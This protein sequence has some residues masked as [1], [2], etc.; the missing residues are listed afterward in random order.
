[1]D[2][3][4]RKL[5]IVPAPGCRSVCTRCWTKN[6][7]LSVRTQAEGWATEKRCA[8]Q[9]QLF[10][11]PTS[12]RP[13][14]R[15]PSAGP[16]PRTAPLAVLSEGPPCPPSPD[17]ARPALPYSP[18]VW[19]MPSPRDASSTVN[20]QRHCAPRISSCSGWPR[21]EQWRNYP[22]RLS[23]QGK[24][25]AQATDAS[26]SLHRT[27]RAGLCTGGATGHRRRPPPGLTRFMLMAGGGAAVNRVN[28]RGSATYYY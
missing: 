9:H 14:P 20:R 6:S 18:Q 1:M 27:R 3:R 5:W 7:T 8:F 19:L 22:L 2:W 4:V 26:A 15:R 23:E 21:E 24:N 13:P 25:A 10:H 16:C 12:R 11:R 17:S 28:W